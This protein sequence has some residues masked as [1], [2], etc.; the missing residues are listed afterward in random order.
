MIADTVRTLPVFFLLLTTGCA[1][2]LHGSKDT[3]NFSS[4]ES[5]TRFYVD[6]RQVGVGQNAVVNI[7]KKG[8]NDI[9]LYGRKEGCDEAVAKYETRFDGITLLGVF[10]DFGLVTILLVDGAATGAW[11]RAKYENY[12]LSPLC[13]G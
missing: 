2:M 1:A 4:A 8:N 12:V 5:G 13:G 10:L 7:P 3:I 6:G 9:M 11:T